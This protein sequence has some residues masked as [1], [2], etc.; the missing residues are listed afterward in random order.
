MGTYGYSNNSIS[1]KKLLLPMQDETT[2][3]MPTRFDSSHTRQNFFDSTRRA[4]NESRHLQQKSVLTYPFLII[5][6]EI[7]G[8]VE[9]SS[10]F[11]VGGVIM[12]MGNDDGLDAAFRF[13]LEYLFEQSTW[14]RETDRK[15]A[16]ECNGNV[17]EKGDQIPENVAAFCFQKET[18]LA[19]CKLPHDFS[20]S[21]S[22]IIIDYVRQTFGSV[23][24]DQTRGSFASSFHTFL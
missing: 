8:T 13:D 17:I 1:N 20:Q 7:D 15:G 21:I 10:P 14:S 22:R 12:G 3:K 6:C 9:S 4:M 2:R 19:D 16:D 23:Q 18:S 24:M 11:N 5:R